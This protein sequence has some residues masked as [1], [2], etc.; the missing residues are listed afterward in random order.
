VTTVW[1]YVKTAPL[2]YTWLV[3]LLVT[4]II[5]HSM[6][7]HIHALHIG[8]ITALLIGLGLLPADQVA[9]TR[10]RGCVNSGVWRSATKTSNACAGAWNSR[11]RRSTRVTNRSARFW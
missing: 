7:R 6:A 4:T 3:V 5:Q 1:R 10:G 9:S 11:G 8:V 2:T